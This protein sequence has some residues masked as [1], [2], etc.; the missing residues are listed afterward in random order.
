MEMIVQ[1]Q[2][3]FAPRRLCATKAMELGSGALDLRGRTLGLEKLR[4]KPALHQLGIGRFHGLA[5]ECLDGCLGVFG[6]PA[7]TGRSQ[8]SEQC[9][10]GTDT[11]KCARRNGLRA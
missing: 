2:R 10:R 9:E 3:Q 5:P 1:G 7:A 8:L 11:S 6:R 4:G